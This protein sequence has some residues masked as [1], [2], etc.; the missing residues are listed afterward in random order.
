MLPTT[1]DP[2]SKE[3]I[4]LFLSFMSHKYT[5]VDS[6]LKIYSNSNNF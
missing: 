2:F 4:P 3:M 1:E 5:L 6:A